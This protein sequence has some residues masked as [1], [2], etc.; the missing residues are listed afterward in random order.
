MPGT[1][2]TVE[3]IASLSWMGLFDFP[4]RRLPK[5]DRAFGVARAALRELWPVNCDLEKLGAHR[6]EQ[7]MDVVRCPEGKV[8]IAA[9][10]QNADHCTDV[11]QD[12][13]KLSERATDFFREAGAIGKPLRGKVGALLFSN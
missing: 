9:L 2:I 13:E 5:H 11:E 8:R 12:K 10:S 3:L 6:D 7:C 1:A 4:V